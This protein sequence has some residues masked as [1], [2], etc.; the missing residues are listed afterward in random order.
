[1]IPACNEEGNIESL[2]AELVSTLQDLRTPWEIVFV[3]D[4][5]TDSTWQ[6]INTLHESDRRVKG[7]RLS[8]NF[9]H[10]CALVAGLRSAF[11]DVVISMDADLQHPPEV[12]PA[13]VA[14]WAK[15]SKIVN[16]IRLSSDD[17]T[18]VKKVTSWA[19]Y[20]IFSWLSGVR[21]QNGAADF[22]L[23]DRKVLDQILRFEEDSLFLRGIVQWVGYPSSNV[24]F[25]GRNRLSGSTKYTFRRMLKLAWQGV[26]SFSLVPLR[27]GLIAGFTASL[28][29]FL[30]VI[31]AIYS[32]LVVGSTIPGWTS[33]LAILSF[34]FGILFVYL[35]LLGEYVG[36]IV[37]EVRRRPRYL[38]SERVGA[39]PP[40][41]AEHSDGLA[42]SPQIEAERH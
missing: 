31:Y 37:V 35:G 27:I 5:S 32:K 19:F 2:H 26:S 12:I 9:G 30:G 28:I 8:R 10:Q 34:L 18:L 1:V 21:L 15:G 7:V 29:A 11:G 36:R 41:D 40:Q 24:M 39:K 14:E 23:L 20:A 4:G 3:D 13:L 17:A 6:I 38:I 33:T 25:R 22:R 16:T 42:S